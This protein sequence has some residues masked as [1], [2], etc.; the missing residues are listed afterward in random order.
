MSNIEDQSD[1][2][3]EDPLVVEWVAEIAARIQS[4]ESIDLDKIIQADPQRAAVLRR[5]L[6]TIQ[7]MAALGDEPAAK[8]GPRY[9]PNLTHEHLEGVLGD[10]ELVR[11]LNCGGQGIV[12]EARQRSVAN[13]RV[14]LKRKQTRRI[15]FNPRRRLTR[16]PRGSSRMSP[17]RFSTSTTR[18]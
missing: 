7:M 13:R 4:G 8:S 9:R 11:V 16:E 14:A 10:F 6:P 17:M 2:A 12:Y 5:V 3:D 15:T 1:L 18:E